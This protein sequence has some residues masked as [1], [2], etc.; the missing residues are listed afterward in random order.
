MP[1]LLINLK[2]QHFICS[3]LTL[4][5]VP[6]FL[7]FFLLFLS[8]FFFFSFFS[9]GGGGRRS[10]S[11]P[12]MTPL[13]SSHVQVV[14]INNLALS[15]FDENNLSKHQINVFILIIVQVIVSTHFQQ[16]ATKA[17]ACSC[18]LCT[19]SIKYSSVSSSL[20][21]KHCERYLN[22]GL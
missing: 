11:P 13:I 8:F 7:S 4:F 2:K 1:P 20:V 21:P 14:L 19:S 3:N 22:M 18:D 15:S 10:P 16:T 17:H 12:Q 6:F 5:V 9:W